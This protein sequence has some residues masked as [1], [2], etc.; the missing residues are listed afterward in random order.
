[1]VTR[2]EQRRYHVLARH[3]SFLA[4]LLQRG[5]GLALQRAMHATDLGVALVREPPHPASH[6]RRVARA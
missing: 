3:A 5:V 1:M 6:P 2:L 4:C